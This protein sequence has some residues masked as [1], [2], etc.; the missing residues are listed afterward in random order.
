MCVSELQCIRIFLHPVFVSLNGDIQKQVHIKVV[1]G[2]MKKAKYRTSIEC[3]CDT[4][5]L[6]NI[7][8]YLFRVCTLHCI[9]ELGQSYVHCLLPSA[10]SKTFN[11]SF[12]PL[13]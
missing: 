6:L 3:L 9:D 11:L 4:R 13:F 8:M 2:P 1:F 12:K 5:I 7:Q 10:L